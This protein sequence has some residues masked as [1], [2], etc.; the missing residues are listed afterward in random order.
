MSIV[1]IIILL[2]ILLGAGIIVFWYLKFG[3]KKSTKPTSP[4]TPTKPLINPINLVDPITPILDDTLVPVNQISPIINPTDPGQP[5]MLDPTF[6][7]KDTV[8]RIYCKIFETKYFWIGSRGTLML[9]DKEEAQKIYFEEYI[10]SSPQDYPDIIKYSKHYKIVNYYNPQ[11]YLCFVGTSEYK[12]TTDTPIT[13][14]QAPAL[15]CQDSYTGKWLIVKC[16]K[17]ALKEDHFVVALPIFY[18]NMWQLM[19][20]KLI[21]FKPKVHDLATLEI[22][23]I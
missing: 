1:V 4:T 12:F 17:T 23:S 21:Q 14:K 8:Y 16:C 18:N 15:M 9:P 22:E 10:H 6:L 5:I 3:K 20:E 2:G 19:P 7:N 11:E 13:S